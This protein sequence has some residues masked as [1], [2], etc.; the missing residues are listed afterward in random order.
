MKEMFGLDRLPKMEVHGRTDRFI[1]QEL[2]GQARLDFDQHFIPLSQRYWEL[3]PEILRLT[4]GRLL[5]GVGELLQE[6]TGS[7]KVKLGLL[8]GNARR[9]AQIKLE[10]FDLETYFCFGGYGD[11]HACRN[12]VA[13][14]ALNAAYSFLGPALDT[15]DVWVIGDTVDDVRCARAIGAKAIAVETGGSKPEELRRAV[16]DMQLKTLEHGFD[17]VMKLLS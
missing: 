6:L 2:L 16:P 11:D 10:R 17:E 14:S 5:P 3:L 12:D 13:R 15:N 7:D 8:T 1:F 9:A 4:P